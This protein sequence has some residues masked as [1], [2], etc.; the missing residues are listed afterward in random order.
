[1]FCLLTDSDE[2]KCNTL[3]SRPCEELLYHLKPTYWFAAHLHVKFAAL[4]PHSSVST[5][6]YCS[7]DN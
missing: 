5:Y 6:S 2:V 4:V 3:G 1:M 7:L